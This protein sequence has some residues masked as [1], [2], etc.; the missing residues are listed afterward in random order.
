MLK[1]KAFFLLFML[2]GSLAYSQFVN[3]QIGSNNAP[4]EPSIA[5]DPKHPGKVVAGAN[6]DVFYSSANG[7]F[8]WQE[9]NLTS[10]YGVYGDPCLIVDTAGNFYY[11]HL[12]SP[13]TGAWIDRIVCQKSTDGGISWSDGTYTG[14]NGVKNQDKEWAVVD[15][16]T[17]II[18]VTWTQFDVYGSSNPADS[19][20]ILFSKSTDGGLS[21]SAAKR[22]NRVAGDCLDSDNTAEGAVPAVGPNGEVYVAWA[23]PAGIVFNRSLDQGETWMDTNVFISDIP[24]G[25]DYA[26]PGIYRANGLPVTCCDLSNGP[27]RGNIYVNWSDQ[28]NGNTDTDI[29][30]EKS[31]D[32]GLTWSSRKR[33]ND[34]PPGKQQFFTWMT[35]DQKTGFIYFI[36]YDRRNWIDFQTDVYMAVSRDGGET[37]R[38]FK[39]SEFP[40]NPHSWV[41]FGDYTNLSVCGNVIRPIWTRLENDQLSVWTAIVDSLFTGTGQKP[42]SYLA[43]TLD[44]NYPNPGKSYTIIAYK[45]RRPVS[46]T[47]EVFNLYGQKVATLVDHKMSSP[48]RYVEYFDIRRYGLEPGLY[49]YSLVDNEQSVRRKMIVEQEN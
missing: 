7:G 35:V 18:Y 8:T 27:Y 12:S 10:N 42:E 38:N 24:G 5:I 2:T 25:W 15:P 29:W 32:G 13:T 34:D 41:F 22:I 47:L 49:Y 9:G 17:N 20:I 37:F 30:F 43:S 44:Q 48:G 46:V 4:E 26:I 33:V 23:G 39:V 19:S 40:F 21:W 31:T 36:F 11:F 28:R 14:L 16:R 45:V 3:V 1:S 6:I